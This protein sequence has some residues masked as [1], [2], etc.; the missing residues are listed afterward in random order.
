MSERVSLDILSCS[1]CSRSFVAED[2]TEMLAA[3]TGCCPRCGT[4]AWRLEPGQRPGLLSAL[5]AML[6]FP[7]PI[8]GARTARDARA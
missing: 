8:S 6:G 4:G 5:R 3:A 7:D 1:A 2:G